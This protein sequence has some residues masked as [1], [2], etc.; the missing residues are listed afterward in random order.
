[1]I[2]KVL[3][4]ALCFMLLASAHLCEA[5]Q[6]PKKIPR[7]GVLW[8]TTPPDPF[9]DAFKQGLRELGYI[10]GQ[11]IAIEERW[12][13][14]KPEQLP[15]LAA[16]LVRLRV[17]VIVTRQT[18]PT[19]AAK[20][21]TSSIPIVMA[22]VTD[23]VAV[24]FVTSLAHP[25]G[26]ITGLTNLAP[27]LDGKRLELLKE[28]SP[29]ITRVAFMWEPANLGLE[30]RLKEVQVAAQGLGIMLQSLEVRNSKEL[31]SAFETAATERADALMVPTPIINNH[32]KQFVELTAKK[33][34]LL[35]YDTAEFVEQAGGLMSYG[36]NYSD[37]FR[38]AATYVDKI[39]KGAKP[40]DLPVEQPMK[41]ELVINLKTAKQMGLTIPPSVL[42]RADK[43]IK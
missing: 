39:L 40:A 4:L 36:P 13:E 23:P 18:P 9:L 31:E 8:P 35:I 11:N 25:G 26:N 33:R 42:Y 15:I 17:D 6:Q 34:L 16:E 37:L 43:V 19:Q 22:L 38:R 41:F 2:Q 1:M 29:K 7:I 30:L 10:Q 12:A 14:G 28:I 24:G 21:A 3:L 27:D 20:Q 32:R 5:Q